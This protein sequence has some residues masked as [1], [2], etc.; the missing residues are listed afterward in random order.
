MRL[1]A[2]D[3]RAQL[4]DAAMRLFASQGFDG[5]TT[6]E[7]AEAAAVNE[8]IIFRHFATKEDL[9]WAVVSSQVEAAG[10]TEKMR[11]HL[12]SE[13]DPGKVLA[14]IAESLLERSEADAEL[15]RLLLF[16]ALRN[17]ELTDNFFR[18]YM[19]ATYEL[20]AE[21]FRKMV[22][23]GYFRKMDPLIAARGFIGMISNHILVQELFGG[24]RYQQASP[25]VV[26][27]QLADIWLNGVSQSGY[28]GHNG[29]TSKKE[30]GVNGGEEERSS[31][32]FVP[33]SPRKPDTSRLRQA[34]ST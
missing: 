9:Y 26:G 22:K 1:P 13:R 29:R 15:T 32:G 5:T 23:R 18:T 12:L 31:N 19:A 17:R 2:K 16:S 20:L 3:R 28:N 8:A 6:R 7:I 33:R 34:V 11:Q 10:R 25:R 24:S 27:R 4:I 21:Y 14:A 30:V